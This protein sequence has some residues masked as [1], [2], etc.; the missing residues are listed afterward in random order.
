MTRLQHYRCLLG[1]MCENFCPQWL[2]RNNNCKIQSVSSEWKRVLENT[3][4][5]NPVLRLFSSP[6]AQWMYRLVREKENVKKRYHLS[7]VIYSL[8]RPGDN[9]FEPLIDA[10]NT[11]VDNDLLNVADAEWP[12]QISELLR[13]HAAEGV[14][15]SVSG[16]STGLVVDSYRTSTIQIFFVTFISP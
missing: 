7:L 6:V 3:Y 5:G 8:F 16:G 12:E 1:V 2:L 10:I 14:S 9:C 15:C 13:S 11:V 4:R